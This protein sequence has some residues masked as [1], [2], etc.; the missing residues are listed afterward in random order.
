MQ[1]YFLRQKDTSNKNKDE[2]SIKSLRKIYFNI[3]TI[4]VNFH[5]YYFKYKKKN[6]KRKLSWMP[7]TLF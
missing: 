3:A 1:L 4:T 6:R 2:N 5:F 7:K